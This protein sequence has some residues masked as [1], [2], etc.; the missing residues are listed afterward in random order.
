MQQQNY[1][2]LPDKQAQVK[3]LPEP[4]R[5][6]LCYYCSLP[7]SKPEKLILFRRADGWHIW[8]HESCARKKGML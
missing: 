1:T 6:S 5:H 8:S 2:T 4:T 3:Q 7:G